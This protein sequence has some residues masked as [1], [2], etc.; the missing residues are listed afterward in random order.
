[1]TDQQRRRDL[2]GAP[3]LAEQTQTAEDTSRGLPADDAV[4]PGTGMGWE[5]GQV[6]LRVAAERPPLSSS[7]D[8]LP[9]LEELRT[10][11]RRWY[12]HPAFIVS[13]I[14]TVLAIGAG[15]AWFVVSVV[16][17]PDVRVTNLQLTIDAGN[18]HLDWDGP[19]APYSVIAVDGSGAQVDLSQL[20]RGTESWI[21]SAGGFYGAD[22]CFVVRPASA[23]GEVRMD[24]AALEAEGGASACVADAQQ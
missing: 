13:L 14:L 18:A 2:R 5:R 19:D 11:P 21:Y 15:V 1:M 23:T 4:A 10:P 9:E 7:G 3:A 22:T 12:K 16:L 6:S 24:A 20:V 17:A 8:V